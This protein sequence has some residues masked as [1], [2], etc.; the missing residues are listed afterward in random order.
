[1]S[2]PVFEV[3]SKYARRDV[4]RGLGVP[5]STS[6]GP[7]FTGYHEHDGS[8]YVFTNVG[9]PGRT[10]H[11]YGNRWEGPNL[12]WYAKTGTNLSQPLVARLLAGSSPVHVFWR[13]DN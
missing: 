8:F 12:R 11:D 9:T 4:L 1:M 3:G 7:W 10:G 6:G 2:R 5:D 13:S